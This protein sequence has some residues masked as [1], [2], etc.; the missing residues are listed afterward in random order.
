MNART[1]AV[2]ILAALARLLPGT[3]L[4]VL[5]LASSAW[6]QCAWVLWA[7]SE[8]TIKKEGEKVYI[9]PEW[10][11]MQAEANEARCVRALGVI[12]ALAEANEKATAN[13]LRIPDSSRATLTLTYPESDPFWVKLLVTY[14][15]LPDTVDPRGPKA[16]G[17]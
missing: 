15:C 8:S 6:A 14:V 12:L 9:P 1:F 10:R 3:L 16:S 5:T 11:V 7:Q 13:V 4:A 2:T 17:R